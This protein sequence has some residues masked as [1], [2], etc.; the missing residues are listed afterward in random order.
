M[1]AMKSF[2][3]FPAGKVRA[4]RL[5]NLF[6]SELLPG[7]DN[8]AEMKVTLY[9]FWLLHQKQGAVRYLRRNEIEGDATF[10]AGLDAQPEQALEKL[11][12]ALERATSRG[13]LLHVMVGE[14]DQ[15]YFVN[16][17]KSRAAVEGLKDGKW[18]PGDDLMAYYG[19]EVEQP[20]IFALYEQNV[21][22]LTPL[23]ADKLRDIEASFPENWIGESI[24]I[25]VENNKRSLAYI[26][27]IL[28]RW[29]A[30]GKD[31]GKSRRPSGQDSQRYITG[32]Y[33]DIVEY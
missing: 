8:L 10:M 23:I 26:T 30:E 2:N 4:T 9:C 7:I 29:H 17:A 22:P 25:A 27:A 15:L 19:L 16:T 32:K 28:E 24:S 14:S 11:G 20:N 1:D 12:E 5:P 6:F 33:A 18:Q 31:S 21:G 3:G 13:T